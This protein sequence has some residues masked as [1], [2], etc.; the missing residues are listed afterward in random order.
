MKIEMYEMTKEDLEDNIDKGKT[1]ILQALVK[2]GLI[3]ESDAEDWSKANAV[4]LVKK[5]FF[6]TVSDHWKNSESKTGNYH[7][8]VV[9]IK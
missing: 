5:G 4:F 2:D 3:N 7:Y 9:E 6:R 1:I 8:R